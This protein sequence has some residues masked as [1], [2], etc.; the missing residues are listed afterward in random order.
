MQYVMNRNVKK[1][2]DAELEALR[3][4][5]AAL[6]HRADVLE[7]EDLMALVMLRRAHVLAEIALRGQQLLLDL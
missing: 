7:S 2:D 5:L 1:C 6:S 3:N 4:A